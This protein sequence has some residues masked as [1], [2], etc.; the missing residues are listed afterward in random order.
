MTAVYDVAVIGL[1]AVGSATLYQLSASGAKAIGF[2][3][4]APPH[5]LGSTHGESRITRLGIGEGVHY[6]P[7]A[8]R[9]HAIWR[10]LEATLDLRPGERLLHETGC[11]VLGP[12]D[13]QSVMH[14]KPDFIATTVAAARANGIAHEMLDGSEVRKRF[15]QFAAGDEEAAYY[16]PAGG[17]VSPERAVAAQLR[18]ARAEIRTDTPVLSITQEPGQVRVVTADGEYV[19]GEVVVSA[20]AFTPQFLG[21][22]YRALLRPTRQILHW[23]ELDGTLDNT[24]RHGPV[25]IWAHGDSDSFYGFP[26]IAGGA[27][28]VADEDHTADVDAEHVDRVVPPA[29]SE[30]MYADHLAGRL[31]GMSRRRARVATCIYTETGSG[32]FLVDRHPDFDR[33]FVA[34]PCSGHGF[35]HS[36][37]IGEAIAQQVTLGHSDIS[38]AP[39][40][41]AA[42]QSELVSAA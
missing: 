14:H 25:F 35:K 36:A 12:A 1:G 39:F 13:G 18:L 4:Y 30:Q 33:I 24:W 9:S 31:R 37:A 17:W 5:T 27:V 19:A 34:S 3:R 20:G 38:L 21:A 8:I 11:L 32:E 2:D 41:Y 40:S 29:A 10:E 28:K 22:P 6:S 23:F 42:R 7:F 15:P 26:S 16:E